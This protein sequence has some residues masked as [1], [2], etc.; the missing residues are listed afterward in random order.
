[1][2]DLRFTGGALTNPVIYRVDSISGNGNVTVLE[3]YGLDDRRPQPIDTQVERDLVSTFK[4]VKYTIEDFKAFAIAKGLTLEIMNSDGSLRKYLSGIVLVVTT[5]TAGQTGVS[6]TPT[7]SGTASP[8][9]AISIVVGGLTQTTTTTV[10]G[11]WSLVSASLG[12]AGAKSAVITAS[13]DGISTAV[14][15]NFTTV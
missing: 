3:I 2:K 15:R 8:T 5:P 12:A 11:T 14:T 1:M 7:F 4:K 10:T 6:A 9:T 13:K